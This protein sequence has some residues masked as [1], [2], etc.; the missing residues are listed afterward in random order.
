V[1]DDQTGDDTQ[2]ELLTL[3]VAQ[4]ARTLGISRNTAYECVRQGSIPSIR[5]GHRI[6]VPRRA[7]EAL[8]DVQAPAE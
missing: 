2:P 5:L 8:L 7:L 4:A 6:V 3:S 1:T